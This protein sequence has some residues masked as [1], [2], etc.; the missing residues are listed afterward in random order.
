[1]Y[2]FT[3]PGGL[4]DQIA[5]CRRLELT[6]DPNDYGDITRVNEYC[7]N[8]SETTTEVMISTYENNTAH[9][10]FDITHPSADPFPP[11]YLVGFLNQH[12]VQAA[13]GVPVNH[14]AISSAVYNAFQSTGDHTRQGMLEHIASILSSGIKVHLMYGDR[15]YACNWLGGEA[16]SL[17]IPWEH[18]SDFAEAGYTPL[19]LSPV[20][21]AGLT[22]QYGNLSFSRIYQAGHLVPS[23][24]PEAAYEV[25]MRSLRNRDIATGT[26]DL[27]KV[28]EKGEE[29]A[30]WG[31]RDTWWMKSE[32]LPGPEPECYVLMVGTCTEEQ[33]EWLRDGTAVVKDFILIGREN[34]TESESRTE[35]W[36]S[37]GEQIP[38]GLSE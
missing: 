37:A 30:T 31:P 38:L 34:G 23:Y 27:G 5:E 7:R 8:V 9:G 28:W 6:T 14:T 36:R 17:K 19:V 10:W 33:R 11:S 4:K 12:W 2:E 32:V 13:L 25:F 1:M 18:Q 35:K 3:R 16:S 24:Q 21:S 15:D 20:H 26:V 29:Y 22:R